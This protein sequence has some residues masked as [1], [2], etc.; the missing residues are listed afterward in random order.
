MPQSYDDLIE[1]AQEAPTL[2]TFIRNALGKYY[3]ATG[4]N[5]AGF[6]AYFD[7]VMAVIDGPLVD[8]ALISAQRCEIVYEGIAPT[9]LQEALLGPLALFYEQIKPI[10]STLE[11]RAAAFARTI[12]YAV[13]AGIERL[14]LER[15][16]LPPSP[17]FGRGM[18][19]N[20][21]LIEEAHERDREIKRNRPRPKKALYPV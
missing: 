10:A 16:A 15:A 8:R 9:R 20:Q 14:A 1:P 18:S 11:H 21:R 12:A 4:A 6:E 7:T 5:P 3:M 2:E 19:E 13:T 17:A